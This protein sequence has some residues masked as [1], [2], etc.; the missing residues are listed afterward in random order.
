MSQ[1]ANVQTDRPTIRGKID[2]WTF[3]DS[4]LLVRRGH[5]SE[6]GIF[7]GYT[8]RP[9]DIPHYGTVLEMLADGWKLLA[10]PADESWDEDGSRV[11]QFG[12]WLTRETP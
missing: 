9:K 3:E 5:P 7:I 11:S 10:P 6:S 4:S 2:G 12:W 8:P 1:V